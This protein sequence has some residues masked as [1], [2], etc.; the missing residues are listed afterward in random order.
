MVLSW[1]WQWWRLGVCSDVRLSDVGVE[2]WPMA[3][4]VARNPRD[5]F[6]FLDLLRFSLQSFQDNY[7][8][9]VC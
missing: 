5:R 6:V 4:V 7:F 2:R 8:I 3:S 9:L 1:I